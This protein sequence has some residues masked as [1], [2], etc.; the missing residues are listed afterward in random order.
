M[1][2]TTG[3]PE[4]TVALLDGPI[5][6]GHPDLAGDHIREIPARL[7][8]TCARATS[9]ACIHGTFVAGMLG[10][11][12]TALAPAICPGC[13][14]LVRPIFAETAAQNGEMPSAS[15]DE[16]A[17]AIVDAVEAGG[18]VINVSAALMQPL[19]KD[20]RPLKEALDHAASRG[21]IT[22][23]AAGNQGTLVGSVITRHP[24]V[25]P[26]AAGDVRGRPLIQSNL[27]ASIGRR[28]LSAPGDKITSLGTGKMPATLGGT[29]AATPFV[30]GAVA[31]LWSEFPAASAAHLKLALT[32]TYARRRAM[33]VPPLLDAWAAYEVMTA[34]SEGR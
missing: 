30:T 17:A 9:S 34:A 1:E 28:G 3:R 31:L 10:A 25:I 20:E 24:W 12:R 11:K 2:R 29:S 33:V 22:I 26:V 19:S 32:G 27:G 23:A 5:V 8:G 6:T 18:R 7:R 13:T 21:V 16:L 4:V 15:P 14:L